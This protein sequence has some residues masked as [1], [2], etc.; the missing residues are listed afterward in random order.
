MTGSL[1]S[2]GI[3]PDAVSSHMM[4]TFIFFLRCQEIF[5]QY[6]EFG[7]SNVISDSTKRWYSWSSDE[8]GENITLNSQSLD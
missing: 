5:A 6:L 3:F 7:D 4:H 2:Q 8:G 1:G